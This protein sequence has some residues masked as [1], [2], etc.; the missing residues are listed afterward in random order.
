MA[1]EILLGYILSIAMHM[2]NLIKIF[3]TVK[4]LLTFFDFSR[5]GQRQN[6]FFRI[7]T[8]ETLRPIPNGNWHSLE[9]H[10]V[11]INAYAKFYQNIPNSLRVIDIFHEQAGVKIFTNC[12]VFDYKAFLWNST[13]SWLSLGRAIFMCFRYH[14]TITSL[15]CG[16]NSFYALKKTVLRSSV[17]ANFLLP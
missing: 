9:L 13:F 8:L 12:S 10:L 6:P 15:A 14:N 11:N 16:C 7:W 1:F 4:A 5:T 2:Q 17:W 3:Q